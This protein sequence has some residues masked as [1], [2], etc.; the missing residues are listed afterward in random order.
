MGCG[1]SKAAVKGGADNGS[2]VE[3]RERHQG[4]DDAC[5]GAI[6][7]YTGAPLPENEEERMAKLN[8]LKILDTVNLGSGANRACCLRPRAPHAGWRTFVY[9]CTATPWAPPPPPLR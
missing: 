4:D 6:E 2:T 9:R 3:Q 8:A 5:A 7:D 1:A